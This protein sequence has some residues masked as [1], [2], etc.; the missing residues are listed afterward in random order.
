MSVLE[1]KQAITRLSKRE[2]EDIQAYLVRLNHDTAEWKQATA[3]RIRNMKKGKALSSEELEAR[4][5]A[6]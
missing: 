4:L 2:R 3:Q 6:R 5:C 1:M